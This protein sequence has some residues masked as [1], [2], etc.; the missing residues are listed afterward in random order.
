MKK[1]KYNPQKA[2]KKRK[3]RSIIDNKH[4]IMAYFNNALDQQSEIQ[5]NVKSDS[6]AYIK[7]DTRT[8][9]MSESRS[10]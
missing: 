8:D 5:D 7:P 4:N 10:D 2:P 1:R 3:K 9:V 6:Q